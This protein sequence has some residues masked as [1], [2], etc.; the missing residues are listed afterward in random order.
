[1]KLSLLFLAGAAA[2]AAQTQGLIQDF[3]LPGSSRVLE[4]TNLSNTNPSL[5]FNAAESSPATPGTLSLQSPGFRASVGFY[6][7]SDTYSF[8]TATSAAPFDI[9]T[10]VL[11]FVGGENPDFTGQYLGFSGGPVLTYTHAGGSGTLAP[12]LSAVLAGPVNLTVGPFTADFYTYAWQWDLSALPQS[13]TGI[14]ILNTVPVHTSVTN[15][16]LNFG[17]TFAP[18][19]APVP[20]PA[21]SAALLGGALLAF[22]ASTRRRHR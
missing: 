19:F 17:D 1:M 14:S 4:W 7:F 12:A 20:E 18:Q 8:T 22:A 3:S 10:V 13:I 21:T 2:L 15:L 11:Q 9:G 6:S 16:Q 5:A